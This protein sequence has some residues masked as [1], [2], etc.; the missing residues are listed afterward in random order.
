MTHGPCDDWTDGAPTRAGR[1][2]VDVALEFCTA[3]P[4][5]GAGRPVGVARIVRHA[6]PSR[7]FRPAA[8]A[9]PAPQVSVAGQLTA[10][11]GDEA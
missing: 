9:A 7:L 4:L 2:V 6:R 5:D 10:R 11:N 3:G 8:D 1:Y